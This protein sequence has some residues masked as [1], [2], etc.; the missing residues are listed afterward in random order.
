[1]SISH[2][3]T[4][5]LNRS[6]AL[7]TVGVLALGAGYGQPAHAQATPVPGY[8]GSAPSSVAGCPFI[9]WRLQKTAT[10]AVSGIAYYSDASGV[11]QVTG[12]SA[13]S[14]SGLHLVFRSVTGKGP[15]GT[16]KGIKTPDGKLVAKLTGAGCANTEVTLT[17][18]PDLNEM[19]PHGSNQ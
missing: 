4:R 13:D 5:A 3:V 11:S 10:G 2:R 14:A 7:A 18:T 17:V 9:M 16:V 8:A 6:T 1:M 19:N 15:T 12:T